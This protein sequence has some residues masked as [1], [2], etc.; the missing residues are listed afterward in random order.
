VK[1][2]HIRKPSEFAAMV[3][4]SGKIKESRL[5]VFFR[6]YNSPGGL[7]VGLIVSKKTDPNATGRN[8]IRRAIYST[9]GDLAPRFEKKTDMIVRVDGSTVSVGKKELYAEIKGDLEKATDLI[10]KETRIRADERHNRA[11]K[12]G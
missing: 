12:N 5:T 2:K 1:I 8:Y 11:V 7:S 6:S 9:C 4:K 10:L 3:R